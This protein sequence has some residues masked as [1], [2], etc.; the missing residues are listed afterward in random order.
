MH[1]PLWNRAGL[2]A[3]FGTALIINYCHLNNPLGVSQLTGRQADS[4]SSAALQCP[5]FNPSGCIFDASQVLLLLLS[6]W[7]T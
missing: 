1:K 3:R 2:A 4:K 6:L 5:Q 7:M